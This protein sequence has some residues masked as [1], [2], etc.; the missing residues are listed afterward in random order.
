MYCLFYSHTGAARAAV[1][2]LTKSL[3]LE[4]AASGVRVNSVAPVSIRSPS[5]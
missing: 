4:W 3:A 5:L 1:D 2:N